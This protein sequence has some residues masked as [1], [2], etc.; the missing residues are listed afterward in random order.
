[1]LKNSTSHRSLATYNFIFQAEYDKRKELKAIWISGR[2]IHVEIRFKKSH[3]AIGMEEEAVRCRFQEVS[4]C[5]SF[6][7]PWEK[8]LLL[9]LFRNFKTISECHQQNIY[10]QFKNSLGLRGPDV[11]RTSRRF[12]HTHSCIL[13]K[14][15]LWSSL[16]TVPP[17]L[18]RRGRKKDLPSIAQ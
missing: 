1:M 13:W 10:F 4:N 6:V 16:H 8:K 7:F 5:Y 12:F 2:K 17:R 3:I 9:K 15:T 11:Y 18:Q 14:V